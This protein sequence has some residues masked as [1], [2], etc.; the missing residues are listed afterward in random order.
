MLPSE[1]FGLVSR[2]RFAQKQYEDSRHTRW[3]DEKKR[4]EK[5]VDSEI[6]QCTFLNNR[7]TETNT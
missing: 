5:L 7:V 2:M 6:D 1:F 3:Y 4:L